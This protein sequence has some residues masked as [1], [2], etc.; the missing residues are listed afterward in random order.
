M[1]MKN[2]VLPALLALGLSACVESTPTLQIQ[3]ATAQNEDCSFGGAEGTGLLRGSLDLGLRSGGYSVVLGVTSNV[4][5]APILVGE[6]PV[7]ADEDLDTIYITNLVLRYS[8]ETPELT[9]KETSANV[10]VYG[11]LEEDGNLLLGLLTSKVLSDVSTFLDTHASAEVL[12]TVQLRGSNVSGDE[13]E[14]NE[15]VFPV[16]VYRSDRAALEGAVC[17]EKKRF[18]A[19]EAPCDQRGLNNVVPK[20]ED[21]PTTPAP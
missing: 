16:A 10:P 1:K 11:T 14:S 2:S 3:G 7:G 17:G 18:A 20:C 5:N 8:T 9:F 12:V 15:I 4:A 6:R 19:P 13:V 21:V